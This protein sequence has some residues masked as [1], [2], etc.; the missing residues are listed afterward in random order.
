MQLLDQSHALELYNL[1]LLNRNYLMQ[2]LPWIK[3]T[4]LLD[5]TKQ[6]IENSLNEYQKGCG[7][8]Y[9]IFYDDVICGVNGLNRADPQKK[10]ANIG[11][12]LAQNA[13]GKG[14]I[15]RT[16]RELL[17]IGFDEYKLD[18]IEIR[19]AIDNLKSRA[20]PERL[21]FTFES[22]QKHS[23]WLYTHFVDHAIYTLEAS[24]FARK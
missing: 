8:Q 5:H 19:C 3:P 23:E 18:K 15:T 14:I 4:Y 6:F 16:T 21:G 24:Q 9:V 20:I 22:T 12:W 1:T 17:R 11:Y 13:T 2:W 7:S 10:Q